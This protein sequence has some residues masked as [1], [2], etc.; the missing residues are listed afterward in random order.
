MK[1][2]YFC[3]RLS[4]LY[5]RHILSLLGLRERG[6]GPVSRKSLGLFGSEKLVVKLQSACFE[7]LI[8]EH[9]LN[10]RK[11]KRIAKFD[12]LEPLRCEVIKGNVAPEIGPKSFGAFEKQASGT[13]RAP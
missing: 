11:S 13:V 2:V 12:G 5:Q 4:S 10:R 8:F 3:G 6:L 9:V 1:E 7:K